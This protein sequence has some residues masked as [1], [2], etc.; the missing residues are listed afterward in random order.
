[1]LNIYLNHLYSE[2]ADVLKVHIFGVNN[3]S[4][5]NFWLA[6]TDTDIIEF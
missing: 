4:L 2:E 3:S 5:V 1:M 6:P